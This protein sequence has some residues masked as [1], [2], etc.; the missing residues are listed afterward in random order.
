LRDAA[1]P[2]II[3]TMDHGV[4][5]TIVT[6][7]CIAT[8]ALLGLLAA[9]LAMGN[10]GVVAPA[11]LDAA[12]P[13]FAA[14]A[15]GA[16]LLAAAAIAIA[17]AR[18]INAVVALFC[19]GCAVATFAMRSGSVADAVFAGASFRWLGAETIAWGVLVAIASMMAFRAGG[20]LPDV[21]PADPD[22]SVLACTLRPK[23]LVATLAGIVVVPTL[24]FA[25]VGPSKGQS[26]G[27]CT[28]AGMATALIARLYASREQPALLF[29]APVLVLGVAQLFMAGQVAGSLDASFASGTLS[30]LLAAMPADIAAGSLCGVAIGLGWTKGLVKPAPDA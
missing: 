13:G 30:P 5:R 8:C 25:L 3:R 15:V 11:L 10:R 28:V 26:I 16:I 7:L 22:R 27:A 24:I 9:P 29:A 23:A 6:A 12:N 14:A 2:I 20:A 18:P 21:P 1:R 19:F 17:L 4:P